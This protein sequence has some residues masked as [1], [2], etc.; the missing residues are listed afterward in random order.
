MVNKDT[1]EEKQPNIKLKILFQPAGRPIVPLKE[2]RPQRRDS[3]IQQTL[4]SLLKP[5]VSVATHK[6]I[7]SVEPEL[8]KVKQE[9][10]V[11]TSYHKFCFQ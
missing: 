4:L 8:G 6:C 1:E 10:R 3:G 9:Q 7:T 5:I 2:I 11:C